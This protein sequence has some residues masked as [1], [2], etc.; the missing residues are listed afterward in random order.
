MIA[1]HLEELEDCLAEAR[2]TLLGAA[3]GA[4]RNSW[5][6]PKTWFATEEQLKDDFCLAAENFRLA[7]DSW[8]EGLAKQEAMSKAIAAVRGEICHFVERLRQV[9]DLLE[10]F[11]PRSPEEQPQLVVP[12]PLTEVL[13]RLLDLAD[14]DAAMRVLASSAAACTVPGLANLLGIESARLEDVVRHLASCPPALEAPP[15]GGQEIRLVQPQRILVLPPLE[16]R[17][18]RQLKADFAAMDCDREL[19][20]ADTAAGGVGIVEIRVYFPHDVHD[21]ITPF[22]HHHFLDAL[23]SDKVIFFP[24]GLGKLA[25]QLAAEASAEPGLAKNESVSPNPTSTSK[26]TDQ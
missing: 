18:S 16:D 25:L 14:P 17:V 12:L 1:L 3:A 5:W 8:L 24:N 20:I 23:R 6:H 21:V 7:N 11:M 2:A 9:A 19:A 4:L 15:W 26:G 13:P 22:L 10:A